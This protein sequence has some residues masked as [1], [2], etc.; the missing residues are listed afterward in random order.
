MNHGNYLDGRLLNLI[1]YVI[2]E[3]ADH[4]SVGA[5]IDP[6]EPVR[7]LRYPLSCLSKRVQKPVAQAGKSLF[8]PLVGVREIRPCLRLY[9]DG[10]HLRAAW[11]SA[12]A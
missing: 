3:T 12:M 10:L 7:E 8:V 5:C 1:D 2:G 11:I 9:I 6:R 4:C